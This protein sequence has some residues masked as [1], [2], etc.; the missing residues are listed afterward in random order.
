[1]LTNHLEIKDTCLFQDF[2][3]LQNLINFRINNLI[4]KDQKEL[5]PENINFTVPDDSPYGRII[6]THTLT[7]LE[8]ITLATSLAPTLYPGLLDD[9]VIQCESKN[10]ILSYVGGITGNTKNYHGLIPTIETVLFILAGDDAIQRIGLLKYFHTNCK[11]VQHNLIEFFNPSPID[12]FTSKAVLPTQETIHFIATAKSFKPEYT[13]SFPASIL[14]SRQEWSDLILNEKTIEEIEEINAWIKHGKKVL[15]NY[16]LSKKIKLG[17][18]ALF[19]GPPGTGKTLTAALLGKANNLDVY[20]IDLSMVVSKYIG[21]TEKNLANIFNRAER[22]NWILFFDE[23]D[24]LFGKRTQA[25]DAHDRY[26]NQ[27]ISYLLQR[28]EDYPGLIILATNLKNNM[29]DAFTRRFQSFIH[30]QMP[31]HTM[32][33]DLWKNSLPIE[34]KLDEDVNL[35][36]I[37]ENYELSGGS[38]T[39][40]IRYVSLMAVNR[41]DFIL[42]KED[43]IK[44]IAK[45]YNKDG[46]TLP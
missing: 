22:Q 9:L 35:K 7:A 2:E 1:M 46:K 39:N 40:V 21:E 26:A 33:L 43:F 5:I 17:Y 13:T 44:G 16:G 11:L 37:A 20:R 3:I 4:Q 45:E 25:K 32:R 15:Y 27:E 42:R 14:E 19:Y 12:P 34:M 24:A 6:Q 23:A 31:D 28:I 18:R 38:I 30:F 36:T 8:R 10:H 41:E 29:D